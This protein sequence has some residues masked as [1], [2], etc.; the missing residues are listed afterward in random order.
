MAYQMRISSPEGTVRKN[1]LGSLEIIVNV[2]NGNDRSLVEYQIDDR[3]PI[4]LKNT[5]MIDPFILNYHNTYDEL[6]P[7]W[8]EPMPS[9]H[10]WTAPMPLDIA[11]GVHRIVVRTIDPY[12]NEFTQPAVFEVE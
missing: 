11:V 12:G 8:V 3:Q 5:F 1:D 2:F 6:I 9:T 4:Q 7:D 10:I